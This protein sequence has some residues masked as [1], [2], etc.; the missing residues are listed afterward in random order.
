MVTMAMVVVFVMVG[1]VVADR[2]DNFAI[3]T[4]VDFFGSSGQRS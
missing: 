4:S 2:S 1:V 3:S